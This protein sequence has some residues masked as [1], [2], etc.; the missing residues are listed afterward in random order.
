M[1]LDSPGQFWQVATNHSYAEYVSSV[2]AELAT[3]SEAA[4]VLRDYQSTPAPFLVH[5]GGSATA[6]DV[7]VSR[8][9]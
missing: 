6:V 2:R 9:D 5:P 3:D 8:G 1:T 7:P 4:D